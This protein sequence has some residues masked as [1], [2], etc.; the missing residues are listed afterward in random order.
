MINHLNL[1]QTLKITLMI[2]KKFD[3][4]KLDRLNNPERIKDLP[5]DILF[6]Q[7]KNLKP[8]NIVDLGAGTGF[9][10]I[11]LAELFSEAM[12]YS[13]DISETLINWMEEN[14]APKYRNIKVIKSHENQL[15]LVDDFADVLIMINLHHE[16]DDP[17]NLLLECRR[18]LKPEGIIIISD[19]KKEE[20]TKGPSVEIKIDSSTTVNQLIKTGFSNVI[21]DESLNYNYIVSCSKGN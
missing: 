5:I 7:I 15:P 18:I 1:Y 9:Y 8:E 2:E 14:I 19:W 4:A 21:I 11:K 3:P 17:E 10:S 6:K 16:L 13:L 12:I 20:F